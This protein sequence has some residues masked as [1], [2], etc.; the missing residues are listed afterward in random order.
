MR[1]RIRAHKVSGRY[2][3]GLDLFPEELSFA[4]LYFATEPEICLGEVCRH[5]TPEL[6]PLLNDYRISELSVQL[7]AILR[8]SAEKR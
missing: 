3:R 7:E 8:C 4:A 1:R 2:N 5:V 6:L